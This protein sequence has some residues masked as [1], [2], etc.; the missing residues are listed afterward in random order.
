MISMACPRPTLGIE[1]PPAASVQRLVALLDDMTAE[2][3]ARAERA[4][5][6]ARRTLQEMAPGYTRQPVLTLYRPAM[7]NDACPLCT[8]WSCDGTNCPAGAAPAPTAAATVA[9]A[10]GQ[11][12]HCGAWFEDWNGGTCDACRMAGR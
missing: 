5:R 10:S 12:Q 3:D 1:V 6:R 4:G 7:A 11:C 9:A 2:G 8:R